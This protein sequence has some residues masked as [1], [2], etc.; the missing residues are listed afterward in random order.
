MIID[1]YGCVIVASVITFCVFT[2][3]AMGAKQGTRR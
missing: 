2:I 1:A 3:I